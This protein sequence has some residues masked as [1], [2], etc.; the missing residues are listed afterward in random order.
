MVRRSPPIK[1]QKMTQY[2]LSV[3]AEQVQHLFTQ[4]GALARLVEGIVQQILEAQV[5]ALSRTSAP[6]SG[7]ATATATSHAP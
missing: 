3:D 7:A 2:Q 5:S 6:R 4:D 1:E